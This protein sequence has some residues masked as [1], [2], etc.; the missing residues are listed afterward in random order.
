MTKKINTK[1]KKERK[2]K[3]TGLCFIQESTEK[4]TLH[5]ERFFLPEKATAKNLDKTLICNYIKTNKC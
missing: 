1:E 3:T 4:I 5:T 2:S